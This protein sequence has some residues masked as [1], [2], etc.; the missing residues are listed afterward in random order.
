M[1]PEQGPDNCDALGNLTDSCS[2]PAIK[3]SSGSVRNRG[4]RR[5][6][7]ALA[8]VAISRDV[9]G[10][11]FQLPTEIYLLQGVV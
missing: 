10:N 2:T 1:G 5:K 11:D 4:G 8:R 7:E 3:P 6:R 9:C